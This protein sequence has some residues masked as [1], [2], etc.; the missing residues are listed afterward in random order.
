MLG[1]RNDE[2]LESKHQREEENVDVQREGLFQPNWEV[3][4]DRE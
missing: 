4:D 1:K 2:A 3:R